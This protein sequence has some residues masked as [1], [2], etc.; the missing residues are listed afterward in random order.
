MDGMANAAM[1]LLLLFPLA[2][3]FFLSL[4]LP[5]EKPLCVCV[6]V[7]WVC[8]A[9]VIIACVVREYKQMHSR[10]SERGKLDSRVLRASAYKLYFRAV[11]EGRWSF[12]LAASQN[13]MPR[14][15]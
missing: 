4:A 9:L 7:V 12:C 11:V 10:W 6:G 14:N 2:F 3:F 13:A 8:A 15:I 5:V 1:L